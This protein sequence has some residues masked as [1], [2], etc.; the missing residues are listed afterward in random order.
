MKGIVFD[1]K[2]FAVH[3]GPGIRSSIF[4]KGCALRCAWCQNPEG[5][6]N[7]IN[8]WYFE[9]RCIQCY[10]CLE[11]CPE[12]AL[13]IGVGKK[14][15]III[16]QKKCNNCGD[17]SE[18]CP[19]KAL[20]FDSRMMSVE[21]VLAEVLKDRVFYES[22]GGGI[23]LSGGD[24]LFQDQ[25]NL[26]ILKACKKEGLHTAVE[27]SLFVGEETLKKF[28]GSV[29]L[30]MVDIKT[31]DSQSHKEYTGVDN[32]LI[33]ANF[34]KLAAQNVELLVRVPMIPGFTSTEKNIR[35]IAS[36]VQGV[37]KNIPIEL[38]NFNPL[39][40]DK[41][42]LMNQPYRMAND[43]GLFSEEAMDRFKAMIVN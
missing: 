29:D 43:Q 2:R 38:L 36:Y 7:R 32:R 11:V 23:T 13:S 41:Y 14:P 18:S 4:S 9:S 15:H 16:N 27:T 24:P 21:E 10:Q 37:G 20:A 17:C 42:R 12:K 26:E 25:F 34:E 28:I 22:S 5:L 31:F 6:E 3:D 1:I 8:L 19:T 39:A 35:D 33:K 40:R 30:F